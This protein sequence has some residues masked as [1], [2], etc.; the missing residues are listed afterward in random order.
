[1]IDKAVIF[2][3][4]NTD[5]YFDKCVYLNTSKEKRYSK[6]MLQKI[7]CV[8]PCARVRDWVGEGC[9]GRMDIRRKE[10]WEGKKGRERESRG[11]KETLRDKA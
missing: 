8:C 4:S 6:N 1:M 3:C 10:G 7:K 2:N 11:L 5:T 9:G